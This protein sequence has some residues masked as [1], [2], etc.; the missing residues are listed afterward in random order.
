MKGLLQPG[1]KR[2]SQVIG[3][4]GSDTTAGRATSWY[5]AVERGNNYR[6]KAAGAKGHGVLITGRRGGWEVGP[7]FLCQCGDASWGRG[8]L[9]PPQ[10]IWLW[11]LLGARAPTL[12]PAGA[13]LS[14]LVSSLSNRTCST[15]P[16]PMWYKY[17]Q[18]QKRKFREVIYD[19]LCSSSPGSTSPP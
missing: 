18:E 16:I 1:R 10:P 12:Q 14:V 11:E 19:S 13:E 2:V 8:Y 9:E 3:R 4:Q 6:D 5:K 17:Q 15:H 7:H